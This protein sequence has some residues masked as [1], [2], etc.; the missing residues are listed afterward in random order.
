MRDD[1]IDPV[2]VPVPDVGVEDLTE[3]EKRE[4]EQERS[5]LRD[6]VKSLSPDDLKSGNW[7]S[8]LIARGLVTYT[9]RA[10]WQYFQEKYQGVPADAIVDQRIKMATRYAA[11][12]GGL[13]A[14]AYTGA[15]AATIGTAGGA[16]GITI[17]AALVT[18]TAD[19][20]FLTQLQLRL[21]YDISVLYRLR[22][23]VNDPDDLWKLIRVAF[24]IK[25]GEVMGEG[26]LKV[27]PAALRIVIKRFY[28]GP[29]LA[30]AR[31]LPYVGKYLL[32]R[33]VIKV[34]IPLVGIPLAVGINFYTTLIAGRHA[35]GVFRNE[36][37]VIEI[38]E[39]LC[40]QS[41]H[42]QLLMW[43]AWLVVTADEEISDDEAVLMRNLLRLVRDQRDV[44][45]EHL[46]Q[47]I[48]VDPAEVWRRVDAESGDLSDVVNAASRVATVDG[49]A[50]AQEEAILLV[51]SERCARP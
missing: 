36:A 12:S 28:S 3:A 29:V 19:L 39:R 49:A 4:F 32:Q 11:L 24:T 5:D 2:P 10:T 1:P 7:F 44:V 20:A 8:K 22:I 27:V 23:D 51:L 17:P 45:D 31:G 50:N 42:P 15:L 6:F 25:G 48:D 47:L 46:A 38:A 40:E 13:T 37:R 43:V 14:S 21:A 16:S 34:A 30:A 41:K 9:Q 35:R 26:L 33:T 18:L